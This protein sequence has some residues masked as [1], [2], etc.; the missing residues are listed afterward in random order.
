ME[1]AINS[2]IISFTKQ[3]IIE[4]QYK[5]HT[6][7]NISDNNSYKKDNGVQ[8]VIAQYKGDYEEGYAQKDS[9]SSD[10]VNEMFDLAGDRRLSHR[11]TRGQVSYSAHYSPVASVYHYTS[12]RALH[13]VGREKRQIAG[14]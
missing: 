9:H 6:F 14:L 12:G 5:W 8:P 1:I 4:K 10:Y 7:G 3:Y 2:F 11:Q 13:T